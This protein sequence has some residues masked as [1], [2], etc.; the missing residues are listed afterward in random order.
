MQ[1]KRPDREGIEEKTHA[2]FEDEFQPK[3]E[4]GA[5]RSPA[6]HPSGGV[7]APG[8]ERSGYEARTVIARSSSSA[9][10][11][12]PRSGYEARTVIARSRRASSREREVADDSPTDL[13]RIYRPGARQAAGQ[14]PHGTATALDDPPVGWLVVVSGPGQGRTMTLGH[15]MNPIG[16]DRGERVCIDFGDRMISRRHHAVVIYDPRGKKFYLQHG[17]GKNLTYLGDAPV[18]VPTALP[19]F[20]KITI[21]ETVLV[22]VPL[23]GERFDWEDYEH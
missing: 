3:G 9:T 12:T 10:A 23:C 5:G 22:F 6:R 18:L 17:G 2:S 1:V 20:S 14:P 8:P 15:G 16:R 4:A 7:E 11:R 21:G 13:T 19:G